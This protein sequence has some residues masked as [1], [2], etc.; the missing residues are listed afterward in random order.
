VLRRNFI[1]GFNALNRI[2]PLATKYV[3]G[4]TH[5]R[6]HAGTGRVP[7]TPVPAA[8]QREALKLIADGMLSVNSFKF[9]PDFL[10]R[11]GIDQL[12]RVT[13]FDAGVP[14]AA[15]NPNVSLSNTVIRAQRAVLDQLMSEAV[16][17]RIVDSELQTTEGAAF[18]LSELYDTLQD[19]VWAELK[20]GKEIDPL[21][22]NLQREHVKRV[23]AAMLRPSTLVSTDVRSL[24]RENARVL[25][26]RV[27]AVQSK[28]GLSKESR[29]HLADAANS[30]DEA[31][32]APMQRSG[33]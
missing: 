32:R 13:A 27:K 1:N 15:I 26:A 25:L 29:A 33:V 3:G 30:L 12:E 31:L 18:K 16:A 4:I 5:L 23:A 22:R 9:K 19:A 21:R 10:Q 14:G 6:D 11:L 2:A 20:S 24:Q 28:A 8:K 17:Q 7:F